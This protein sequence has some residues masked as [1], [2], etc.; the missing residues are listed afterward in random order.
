MAT[1]G[2]PFVL[3]PEKDHGSTIVGSY[4]KKEEVKGM[5]GFLNVYDS[6]PYS[7]TNFTYTVEYYGYGGQ[8]Y[9][10]TPLHT[11][12]STFRVTFYYYKDG[13]KSTTCEIHYTINIVD[14]T[15]VS[16][17]EEMSLTV[18]ENS[19]IS[20]VIT[21]FT[22]QTTCSWRSSNASIAS[23]DSNGKVSANGV[24]TATITCTAHNG[25]S[26]QSMVTVNPIYVE[27][28]TLNKSGEELSVGDKLQL[29][30]SFMPENASIKNVT[31]SSTN[32]A[33]AMVN[34]SGLVYAVSTGACKI[35]ATANDGSGK[36]ASCIVNVAKK[37]AQGDMN[38]DG[39]LS[40]TDVVKLIHLILQQ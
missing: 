28:V 38:G 12:V 15:S 2:V 18:G 22:A 10:I 5:S 27:S 1:V 37:T 34:E 6:Y 20:P 21:P 17:P 35:T 33:V 4:F 39:E 24:G 31:W 16:I 25:V 14:V 32:E 29:E 40:V 9:T 23:V 30:A 3:D 19:D 11:G 7:T 36:T 13:A 26:G 8:I